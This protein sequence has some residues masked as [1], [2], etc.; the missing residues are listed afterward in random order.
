V[1]A[2]QHRGGG[3]VGPELTPRPVRPSGSEEAARADVRSNVGM[4]RSFPNPGE[5]HRRGP[6]ADPRA[7]EGPAGRRALL[8]GERHL[9]ST[10]MRPP[11]SSPPRAGSPVPERE[12]PARQALGELDTPQGRSAIGG[13]GGWSRKSWRDP[14]RLHRLVEG[15]R[16]G[17]LFAPSQSVRGSRP[18][19]RPPPQ[20][21]IW[22]S[23]RK[24]SRTAPASPAS[25]RRSHSRWMVR[26]SA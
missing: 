1:G 12:R 2:G 20:R 23:S 15:C 19:G 14:Q 9:C 5:V 24:R 18:P 10:R 22:V 6:G 13:L 8:A 21:R 26:A 7:R 11:T 16:R 17:R 4:G 25:S 3:G